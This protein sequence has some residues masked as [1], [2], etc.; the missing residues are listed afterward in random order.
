MQCFVTGAVCGRPAIRLGFLLKRTCLLLAVE[1][2]VWSGTHAA[3][4][5]PEIVRDAS[6]LHAR[7]SE[8]ARDTGHSGPAHPTAAFEIPSAAPCVAVDGDFPGG[9]IIVERTAG[10]TVYLRPDLRDTEGWWFYWNFRVAG[11]QGRTLTFQFVGK[12]PIGVRGPAVSPDGGQRW[13]WLGAEAVQGASFK[14]TFPDEAT[15]VRFCLAMPYQEADLRT[16]VAGHED[17]AH[18]TVQSLCTTKKGRRVERLHVGRLDGQARHKVLLTARHHACEMMASYVMEGLLEAV[19]ADRGD[20]RW[21]RRNVEVLAIP[22]MDKDGVE[23][24]DQG[25]NRKPHDHNRDYIGESIYPSVA[26]LRTFVSNWSNGRLR[27]AFDL[28]CPYLSGSY[29]EVIYMVGHPDEGVWQ[30]QREFGRILEAMQDG[31]LLYRATDNLPFGKAWNTDRNF[32][33]GKSCS[34]WASGLE[35]IRLVAPFEI[36]YANAN[37]QAVTPG[38]A[39]AFGR[40][41]ARAL[42]RYLERI[43]TAHG[44]RKA[45]ARLIA[46]AGTAMSDKYSTLDRKSPYV[47]HE[48]PGGFSAREVRVKADKNGMATA[49][50]MYN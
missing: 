49:Y 25:K 41:L 24:G 43:D 33:K 35:G 21:F 15:D 8:L 20:G 36:P 48:S 10:D 50:F 4:A 34:R 12:D 42:R 22:F 19:L 3:R 6:V 17:H 9:N 11:A 37:G 14:Y 2:C 1:S 40:R 31:P 30:E 27:A 39:R 5:G 23:E 13:S 44:A 32:A 18:L 45:K 28:H 7:A 29:N 38:T 16:F 26:A 47:Q 46:A